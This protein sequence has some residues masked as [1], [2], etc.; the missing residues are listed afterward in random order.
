M[1]PR[2]RLVKELQDIPA[3]A[4]VVPTQASLFLDETATV[5]GNSPGIA[6]GLPT[7]ESCVGSLAAM[8]NM[9]KVLD[10]ALTAKTYYGKRT[11]VSKSCFFVER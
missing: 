9:L 6:T 8:E 11:P 10:P 2:P 1:G 5:L 3:A 7:R 4:P